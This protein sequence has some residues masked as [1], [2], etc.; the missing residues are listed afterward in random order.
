MELGDEA[1]GAGHADRGDEGEGDEED[2]A[3][4]HLHQGTVIS[5]VTGMGALVEQA[6]E[7]E[8]RAGHQ[9][10]RDHLHHRAGEARRVEGCQPEQHHAHVGDR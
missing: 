6:D 10:V 9:T 4:H 3:R 8:Q 1:G 5:E 7:Q 2:E